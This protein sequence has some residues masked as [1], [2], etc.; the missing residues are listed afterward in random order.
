ME[1][2]LCSRRDVGRFL[3]LGYRF[4]S[5]QGFDLTIGTCDDGTRRIVRGEDLFSSFYDRECAATETRAQNT[6]EGGRPKDLPACEL[7]DYEAGW[8]DIPEII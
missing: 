8:C 6:D 4:T 5:Y 3:D 1:A 2:S 7:T